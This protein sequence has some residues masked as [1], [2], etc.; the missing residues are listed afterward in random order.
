MITV[1]MILRK[2]HH[3][4]ALTVCG[5]LESAIQMFVAHSRL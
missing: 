4:P 1:A 3:R 5:S 2:A